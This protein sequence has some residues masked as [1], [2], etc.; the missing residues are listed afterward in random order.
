ML[1]EGLLNRFQ[2][3]GVGGLRR[4]P[5]RIGEPLL[6]HAISDDVTLAQQILQ[7]DGTVVLRVVPNA[8]CEA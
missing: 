8:V 7:L 1:G 5:V 6:R 2:L 4:S 3:A